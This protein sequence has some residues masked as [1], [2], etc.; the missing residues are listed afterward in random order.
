MNIPT[1]P[2]PLRHIICMIIGLSMALSARRL[3]V[4]DRT[5]RARLFAST[6]VSATA[7]RH[8]ERRV[9][10]WF[11]RK[12]PR[13]MV[14]PAGEHI[15]DQL[16]L[17]IIARQWKNLSPAFKKTYLRALAIPADFRMYAS[18]GGNFEIY[19]TTNPA[20]GEA[21]DTADTFG[22]S[23]QNWREKVN[24]PNGIPDYIDI[25]AWGMDSTW[26]MEI[27]RFGFVKPVAADRSRGDPSKYN[28][29]IGN[30][31]AGNYGLT[32]PGD[33]I[34]AQAV[35]FSSHF[36]IRNNWAGWEQFGYDTMPSSGIFVTAAHEFFHSI[37]YAMTHQLSNGGE[38]DDFPFSWLE[39]TATMMEELAFPEI[40]DYH[41]YSTGFFGNP[42]SG[43]LDDKNNAIPNYVYRHSLLMLYL[44]YHAYATPGINFV[45]N[46][47]VTNYATKTGFIQN[48]QQAGDS[49]LHDWYGLLHRF[50]RAS[51]FTG[52]RADTTRFIPDAGA[53]DEW[54][55]DIDSL[56]E[57]NSITKSVADWGMQAF[58]YACDAA[59]NEKLDIVFVGSDSALLPAPFEASLI[60][61][62]ADTT[63]QDSI[64]SIKVS[65]DLL[66][67]I[68][69][70]PVSQFSRLVMMVTNGD[71]DRNRQASVTFGT[72]PVSYEP[73]D[74]GRYSYSRTDRYKTV[75][76]IAIDFIATDSLRGT[77]R[78]VP[79]TPT[80]QQA[81]ALTSQSLL[82]VTD[83]VDIIFPPAWI[84]GTYDLE[85]R[86]VFKNRRLAALMNTHNISEDSLA[87]YRWDGLEEKWRLV[88]DSLVKQF[89]IARWSFSLR[90]KG[91]YS[92]LARK[93]IP[94][95][96]VVYPNPV[97]ISRLPKITFMLDKIQSVRVYTLEGNLVC[98]VDKN[99]G[100]TWWE[101]R[102]HDRGPGTVDWTLRNNLGHKIVP[103]TY[104]ALVYTGSSFRKSDRPV[105]QKILVLP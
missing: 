20:H 16:D 95:S 102:E 33:P 58:A 37:Q 98:N 68:E 25:V 43:L 77:L 105:E 56:D 21:V 6:N 49:T 72:L 17:H 88:E 103:G 73:G 51:Y 28:V 100:S 55:V 36:T 3:H 75:D 8:F 14:A 35:G 9:S 89:D 4:E 45:R 48:L 41:Q 2:L 10:P 82:R 53:F 97:R 65:K 92:L 23:S 31:G 19:Y 76:S 47:H 32:Y 15:V 86:V 52:A 54:R 87:V 18:P 99:R 61:H 96:L 5:E 59:Q 71:V 90:H 104:Y 74:T 81:A 13:T 63:R 34:S 12:D 93:P 64:V 22:Y 26:S 78:F 11:E 57:T 79:V 66:G 84:A 91:S 67:K 39:G 29:I 83:P 80:Q 27:E 69:V 46:V 62:R 42:Y 44:Y 60:M 30:V 70:F 40:D 85:T 1:P 94:A 38:L 101:W 24:A 7:I 50:H